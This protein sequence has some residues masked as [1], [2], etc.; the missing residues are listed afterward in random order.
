MSFLS[1]ISLA[2]DPSALP[3]ATTLQGFANGVMAFALI[4]SAI[5]LLVS[6]ASWGAGTMTGNLQAA[7]VGRRGVGASIVSALLIGAA[8]AIVNFFFHAGQGIH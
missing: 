2:P 3:G 8:A 5:A 1:D 6:A 7:S 4:V